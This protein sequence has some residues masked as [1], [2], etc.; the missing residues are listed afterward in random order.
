MQ[1]A[2]HGARLIGAAGAA[3]LLSA[4]ITRHALHQLLYHDKQHQ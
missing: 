4:V 3:Q 2:H 1:A